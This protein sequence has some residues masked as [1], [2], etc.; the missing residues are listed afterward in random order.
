MKMH[1]N[2][3]KAIDAPKPIEGLKFAPMAYTLTELELFSNVL[4]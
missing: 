1:L 4:R 3:E 2:Q